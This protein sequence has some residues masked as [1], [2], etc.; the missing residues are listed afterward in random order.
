MDKSLQPYLMEMLGTF[1]LVLV[2]AGAVCTSYLDPAQTGSYLVGI[3]LA[4]GFILAAMLT[5][6]VG[7]SGGCLNPAV[8]LAFWVFRRLEGAKAGGLIASQLLGAALAGL[9]LRVMFKETVL[10]DARFGTP[11][12]NL[13]AFGAEYGSPTMKILVTG[14]GIELLLTFLLTLAI[15]ATL[16]DPRAPQ[17]GGL[18]AG[19]TLAALAVFA[20][21]LTGAATNPARW[22]GPW[23]WEVPV[24]PEA[25]RD[26][27]VYWIGP[28]LGA[29]LAGGVYEYLLWPG[30]DVEPIAAAGAEE[31]GAKK[32]K[33]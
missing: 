30:I 10:V 5:V 26:H 12:L 1:G 24:R 7:V 23:I 21:A 27:A 18:G 15:Y 29:L 2:S 31:P 13:D 17:L 33:E 6:T 4:Q 14:V 16:L 11:H 3:A 22:F 32:D 20:Y 19:L 8:T 9:V 25:A 28:T